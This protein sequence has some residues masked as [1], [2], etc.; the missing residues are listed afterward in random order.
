MIASS[1]W[2]EAVRTWMS[3][4][5]DQAYKNDTISL[6]ED[7]ANAIDATIDAFPSCT[8]SRAHLV[9]AAAR[10]GLLNPNS[11]PKRKSVP[12]G[13]AIE[14]AN[15][16]LEAVELTHGKLLTRCVFRLL[17]AAEHGLSL[18]ELGD[19]LA[20]NDEIIR[21]L[22]A[23]DAGPTFALPQPLIRSLQQYLTGFVVEKN[24]VSGQNDETELMLA[25]YQPPLR[26]APNLF[27]SL[28][29][30]HV[31]PM[32][33]RASPSDGVALFSWRSEDVLAA[34][35]SR[36]LSNLQD[37]CDAFTDLFNYFSANAGSFDT[38][39]DGGRGVGKAGMAGLKPL[40]LL[41]PGGNYHRVVDDAMLAPQPVAYHAEF[42]NGGCLSASG[43][44]RPGLKSDVNLNRRKLSELPNAVLGLLD[45]VG[46]RAI[47]K[48][49]KIL[50][51]FDLAAGMLATGS[52]GRLRALITAVIAACERSGRDPQALAEFNAFIKFEAEF[53]AQHPGS[54][55]QQA[56]NCPLSSV[57]KA[58]VEVEV[59]VATR[60]ARK[61]CNQ[62]MFFRWQNM[63]PVQR[64][65]GATAR[66]HRGIIRAIA[67]SHDGKFLATAGEDGA[68]LIHDAITFELE[69]PTQ[70]H[71][72][73]HRATAVAWS[74][75]SRRLVSGGDD[76]FLRVWDPSTGDAI[77]SLDAGFS[78]QSLSFAQLPK[79]SERPGL[80]AVGGMGGR[81]SLWTTHRWLKVFE[82]RAHDPGP[83][84]FL[85][86]PALSW[87]PLRS[88]GNDPDDS[89]PPKLATCG[90]DGIVKVWDV[91]S[92]LGDSDYALE[93]KVARKNFR[94]ALKKLER[95]WPVEEWSL[96]GWRLRDKLQNLFE[97]E[98]DDLREIWAN[99]RERYELPDEGPDDMASEDMLLEAIKAVWDKDISPIP[100]VA[101]GREA[102]NVMASMRAKIVRPKLITRFKAHSSQVLCIAWSPGADLL[103][104]GGADGIVRIWNVNH[105]VAL[106]TE[107]DPI[108]EERA[109]SVL[110]VRRWV[111][112]V[113]FSP[114]GK[115]IV[116]V[117]SDK[118]VHHWACTTV[119]DGKWVRNIPP[120]RGHKAGIMTVSFAPDA[121]EIA[122]A[123]GD[124]VVMK[125]Q[126]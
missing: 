77:R 27:I 46:V 85:G 14:L 28:L 12:N 110:T 112:G 53:L 31:T 15:Q 117:C 9:A 109:S 119:G 86:I 103:A 45:A 98:V 99:A 113:A 59:D 57:S 50:C 104:S 7:T 52:G 56:L 107:L 33:L 97:C 10:Q 48:L 115:R 74:P 2:R 62:A 89:S 58:A 21:N 67:Y 72:S 105:P 41:A 88:E 20:S 121:R 54:T 29:L 114:E 3:K 118:L 44:T 122:T 102:F 84:E 24:G 8:P 5:S 125:W 124:G 11:R 35:R 111:T 34:A 42:L 106:P 101:E 22:Q 75:S 100:L 51:D 120:Q 1:D 71:G 83:Q 108:D 4:D 76:C 66:A 55:L 30:R 61:V 87:S 78:V 90:D 70:G 94:K 65:A 16:L 116:A 95:A 49:E 79:S 63:P 19:L 92:V 32:L 25:P 37:Q 17:A 80:L 126:G 69:S 40:R 6:C 43:P 123:D 91:S 36:Y 26:R 82:F 96:G 60:A 23:V 81:L 73:G 39:A 18:S 68:V 38:S 93:A 13:S 47:P 64:T